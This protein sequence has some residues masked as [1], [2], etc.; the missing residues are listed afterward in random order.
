M[1]DH[2]F[3]LTQAQFSRLQPLLPNK[4]RG[5]PRVDDRR[6]ISA[7]VHVIR[8]G[9]MW[10][11]APAAYGPHKT[12]YNRFISWSRIGVFD[13]IFATLVTERTAS[14][15][16]MIP[17]RRLLRNSPPGNG[18][19]TI[20][21]PRP[22]CPRCRTPKPWSPTRASRRD[23]FRQALSELKISPCIPR[24]KNRKA[25]TP[26]DA[27]IYQQRNLVERMF[28]RLKDWRRIATRYD[29]S[30]H[31]FMSAICIAATVMFWL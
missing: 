10:R 6:V 26:Y 7:M 2:H 19:A 3:W 25:P 28:G 31:T 18:S 8:G 4:P 24:R 5:V 1:S 12:L 17:S 22:S 30:A 15:T 16:V 13:R 9:L 21:A 11:D 27:K 14:N 20:A 29:R 23:R